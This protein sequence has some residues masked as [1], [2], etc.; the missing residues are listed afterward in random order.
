MGQQQRPGSPGIDELDE[1]ATMQQADRDDYDRKDA[2]EDDAIQ[3]E[4]AA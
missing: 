4:L 1:A 3:E 2:D